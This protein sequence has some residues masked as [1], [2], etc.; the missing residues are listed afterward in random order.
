MIA[1]KIISLLAL[2]VALHAA[3]GYVALRTA[4]TIKRAMET[5]GW[6]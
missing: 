2:A 5:E 6:W 3:A 4:S 1:I